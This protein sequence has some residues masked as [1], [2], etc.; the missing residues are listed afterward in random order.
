MVDALSVKNRR[1][2]MIR[3]ILVTVGCA[4][5]FPFYYYLSTRDE[6]VP[7]DY[8]FLLPIVFLVT[9]SAVQL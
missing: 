2:A 8:R 6:S 1:T 7:H 3:R 9:V 4:D 5:F